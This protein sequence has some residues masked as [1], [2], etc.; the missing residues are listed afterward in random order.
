MADLASLVIGLRADVATLQSDLGKANSLVKRSADDFSKSYT[1]A[2][3]SM[4]SAAKSFAIGLAS[5]IGVGTFIALGKAAID[6]ADNFNKM[7]Q[8]IGIGVESLS[9]LAS[10]A[11]LSDVSLDALQGGLAKLA[12]N[13]ADAAAGGKEQ[14]AAF[15]AMGLSVKDAT[16]NL[17]PMDTLLGEVAGKFAG[18]KDSAEKTALAQ[19]LFGKS[20]ADLIVILN[21]LGARGFAEVTRAAKEYNQVIGGEQAAQSE[22]FNDNLTRLQMSVSGFA[23]AVLREA[24]PA[25]VDLTNDMADAAKTSDGYHDSAKA[26]ADVVV[27]AAAVLRDLGTVFAQ[28]PSDIKASADAFDHFAESVSGSNSQ[29][30]SLLEMLP[31]VKKDTSQGL[32]NFGD[33]GGKEAD[34]FLAW[35]NTPTLGSKLADKMAIAT[36]TPQLEEFNGVL[37]ITVPN[38]EEASKGFGEAAAHVAQFGK[39]ADKATAP[40]V[41]HADAVGKAAKQNLVL[42]AA[43]D[44]LQKSLKQISDAFNRVNSLNDSYADQIADI[45][46]RMSGADDA[47]IQYEKNLRDIADAQTELQKSG[48]TAAEA[49]STTSQATANAQQLMQD[50][51]GW[52]AQQEA[53]KQYQDQ[54][55]KTQ[56]MWGDFADAVFDAVTQSGNFL[57]NLL[58]NLKSI[59]SQMLKEWFRTRVIGAFTGGGGGGGW[60]QMAGA[61]VG[62][63]GGGGGM[64]YQDATSGNLNMSSAYGTA[65]GGISLFNA[66]KTFFGGFESAFSSSSMAS[67][68]MFGTYTP[69]YGAG[70]YAPSA[71]G[72]GVAA[73]GGIYAGYNRYQQ[74]QGGA[75]GIAGAAAYGYG[76]YAATIGVS[77]AMT[78]GIAAGV[79]AIPVVGWIAIAAM[80]ID[81]FS[82]GKLFGTKGEV[83]SGVSTLSVDAAGANYSTFLALKGQDALFG[84]ADWSTENIAQTPEEQKAAQEFYES[85]V[86]TMGQ[87]AEQFGVKAGDLVSAKFGQQFDKHGNPTG[88]TSATIAGYEYSNLKPEE[89]QAAYLAANQLEVLSQFDAKL[90]DTV[91]QF[92]DSAD[93]L[94]SIANGLS[95]AQG[96]FQAGGAFLATQDQT[97]SGVVEL[98]E[99][100]QMAGEAIGDTINRL[101]QAQAQYDQFVG[102]F[103][104]AVN[105]VDDFEAALSGIR[106]QLLANIK[107]ANDLARAAGAAGASEKDLA[108]ITQ[109]AANQMAAAVQ[110]LE[111]SAQALAFSMGLSN[112][113]TTDQIGAEIARLQEKAGA[114]TVAVNGFGDAMSNAAQ[115]ATE[116]MDLL[117]GN[118]SP[119]NDQ[120][121]LQAALGGLRAGTVSES[122][123]LEIG[124]RLYATSQ[125]YTDLFNMVTHMGSGLQQAAGGGGGGI[126]T[127]T[128]GGLSGAER[129]RL[130]D[131]LKQQTEL[132][133][134]ADLQNAN[135]LAQQ[136]AEIAAAKGEDIDAVLESLHIDRQALEARLGLSDEALDKLIADIQA[137]Q[138]DNKENTLSIVDVLNK[139]LL[140]LGGTPDAAP[141]GGTP[142]TPSDFGSGRPIGHGGGRPTETAEIV[143]A[144][145]RGFDRLAALG[146]RSSRR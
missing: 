134:A 145:G 18:Y 136:I 55:Q 33:P 144:I 67:S 135:T 31:K 34:A 125:A 112:V 2:F 5:S 6:T 74:S 57:K 32:F 131:L 81:K 108:N 92:R 70:T 84:G 137:R 106:T 66:G 54:L 8:K 130:N 26:V 39:E 23:N 127:G 94:V 111:Q 118:L 20:G 30:S 3:A 120:A 7:S 88:V 133:A 141:T 142:G 27:E 69:D 97:L 51:R 105:F 72:Y 113:G 99:R 114:G 128:G 71:L 82:G 80:L 91:E 75:A 53:M 62:A 19:K 102:Q 93:Q 103:K 122:Q 86:Q 109:A 28:M 101:I 146:G 64:G 77:A 104:P 116:A 83:K 9:A 117:L 4:E 45:A 65:Q 121:K 17:K 100:M 68:N 132:Q 85:M 119:L 61:A 143:D 138:D 140:Q 42:K 14:A 110:A 47:Q 13:A 76:T 73:A 40:V 11:K 21:D 96:Y 95:V 60:M 49:I 90:K 48:L 10:Q 79:A 59:V 87:Y 52:E 115:R 15:Q 46:A 1:G 107:T 78:G 139:I 58:N 35:L 37:K 16:G 41:K 25:L 12:R 29:L 22:Q 43:F 38:V 63:M 36:L 126:G 89:F 123:V 98:A 129:E 56:D 124:R 24:L 50:T 44:D